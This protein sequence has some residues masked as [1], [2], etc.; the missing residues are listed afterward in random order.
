MSHAN[1][2]SAP[3]A[4]GLIFLNLIQRGPLTG[5][6]GLVGFDSNVGPSL[7]NV[8]GVIARG[9]LVSGRNASDSIVL[10]LKA[11]ITRVGSSRKDCAGRFR[12]VQ[13][14]YRGMY[15]GG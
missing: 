4:N 13:S 3:V 10:A 2:V 5:Q 11:G 14:R 6:A 12:A 8:A 9:D 15:L 7:C 1:R